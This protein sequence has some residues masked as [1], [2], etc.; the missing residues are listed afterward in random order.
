MRKVHL[1]SITLPG[2]GLTS[3]FA[4]FMQEC[5]VY[6]LHSQNHNTGVLLEVKS[7]TGD[8]KYQF[9]LEWEAITSLDFEASMQDADRTTDFGAMCLS[10]LII[11]NV[12]AYTYFQTSRKY[13]GIDFWLYENKPEKLDFANANARL[14]ISGI[15]KAKRSNTIKA[16]LTIKNDQIKKSA[17]T[18]K[19]AFISIVEFSKPESL[20]ECLLMEQN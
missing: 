20:F 14:E 11:K 7:A 4:G 5:A 8:L 6:S 12:T 2:C 10:L 18:N 15:R 17:L 19:N 1:N 3:G 9:T 16:R 13:N